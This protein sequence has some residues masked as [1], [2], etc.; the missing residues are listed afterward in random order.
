MNRRK[1]RNY[2][3][4]VAA[5]VC[6]SLEAPRFAREPLAVA[7]ADLTSA[8][9]TLANAVSRVASADSGKHVGFDTNIY[10]GDHAMDAWK[11]SGEYEWVGYYLGA[12]CHSDDSWSGKR[13][14]LVSNGWGLAVIYVGQQTWGKSYQPVTTS[15]KVRVSKTTKRGK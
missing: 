8:P 10:P 7:T 4:L 11:Q 12:P 6:A 3:L 14:R 5:S 9:S 2:L 1:V 15:H 13:E